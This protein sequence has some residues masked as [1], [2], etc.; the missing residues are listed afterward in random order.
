VVR[1][2]AV[3]C[4]ERL[5]G[6]GEGEKRQSDAVCCSVVQCVAVWCSV[7]QCVAVCCSVL[8]CAVKSVSEC[9]QAVS[10]CVCVNVC[11]SARVCVCTY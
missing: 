8:Q 7:V 11:E 6:R 1:G 5:Y 9:G 4:R 2:V 3:C 10:E